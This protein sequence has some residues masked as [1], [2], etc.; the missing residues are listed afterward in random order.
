M[1]YPD[2][3]GE[4][5]LLQNNYGYS[6]VLDKDY[7]T[8]KELAELPRYSLKG[9]TLT[10]SINAVVNYAGSKPDIL[11]K[12]GLIYNLT[13]KSITSALLVS[14]NQIQYAENTAYKTTAR[15]PQAGARDNNL[16]TI[17]GFEGFIDIRLRKI[18][19]ERF[20]YD[21]D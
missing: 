8:F 17:T 1:F 4:L 15:V 5:R 6:L 7:Y 20:Y 3:A 2:Y 14:L 11:S 13:T 21:N 10:G 12:N 18:N 9:H 16:Q 19:I